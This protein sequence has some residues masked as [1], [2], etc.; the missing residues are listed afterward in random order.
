MIRCTPPALTILAAAL[1]LGLAACG[2]SPPS[3]FYTLASLPKEQTPVAAELAE[4]RGIVAVGPVEIADYLDRPQI[5]RRSGPTTITLLE[6][7]RWAGSLQSDVARVLVDNLAVLL[8]D[9][10]YMVL[11]WAATARA[12][13]RIQVSLT[14]FERTGEQAVVLEARWTL[15]GKERGAV[16]ASGQEVIVE[17]ARSGGA[18]GTVEAMSRM[19]AELSR[20]LAAEA[21]G[22]LSRA[23]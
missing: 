20:R 21:A 10:G 16:L 3:R 18:D 15:Y 22:R 8:A 23:G 6:F 2:S 4:H 1:L 9:S 7:D 14:R 19:L 17:P 12:D 5:V 13:G 11:P